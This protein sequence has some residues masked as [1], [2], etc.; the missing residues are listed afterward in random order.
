[1]DTDKLAKKLQNLSECIY[2]KGIDELSCSELH[3]VISHAVM[4]LISKRW[5]EC[6]QMREK[7]RCACYF[8]AEFLVGKMVFNNLM[9][10]NLTDEFEQALAKCGR[11]LSEVDN[12]GDMA[13]GNGGLGRLAACFLESAATMALPLD[14]Y[15]IKYKFGL[16]KQEIENG[17]QHEA[18]DDWTRSGDFFTVRRDE[19]SVSL[20]IAGKSVT[21]VPY[22]MPIIGFRSNYI[23]TLRL[24]Q[25]EPKQEFDFSEFNKQNYEKALSD[26]NAAENLSR[27]LYPNDSERRGKLL[28]LAQQYFFCAASVYDKMRSFKKEHGG[29]KEFEKYVTIQ[30]ND[31]HPVISI[32]EFIRLFQSEGFTFDEALRRAKAVFNYT[33]HTVMPE[34]LECWDLDLIDEIMPELV[35][36]ILLIDSAFKKEAALA[37]IGGKLEITDG[38]SVNMAYLAVYVSA[39]VNG[40]AKLHTGILKER[41]L[42]TWH[43]IYPEKFQNKTNGITPRRWLFLCNKGLSG[44]I[45]ELLGSEAWVAELELLNNLKKHAENSDVL[46]RFAEIKE[47]NK[48]A[49]SAYIEKYENVEIK[50]KMI[51]DIQIKRLHEYKRQLLNVMSII[52]IYYEIKNGEISD[53]YPTAFIFGAKAAPGYKRAKGIIKLINEV[54]RVIDEDKKVSPF[55]KVHFVHDYNVSYAERLVPAA[56]V[57]EQISTAGT[58][59]S[60]TGNMKFM[61]NGA[62][63]LGTYDGANI[64][65]IDEAGVQNN[66]IFGAKYEQLKKIE[67]SYDPMEIYKT[68]KK[69]RRALDFIISPLISDGGTG[70]FKELYDSL[71]T[72]ADWH[73]AD[74]YYLLYDFDSYLEAKLKINRD[75]RQRESFTKKCFLNTASSAAFSSDRA[76][77]EYA[78]DIWKIT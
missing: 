28:R 68:N 34:A 51:F 20:K 59:A 74:M 3:G 26:K 54:A 45:S 62:V 39:N 46:R 12:V 4:G 21:A 22:D 35:R 43:E 75:Y 9:E 2:C 17:F 53:F 44:L 37:G 58:E 38:K 63:T 61:L 13:L 57:S 67:N 72:G 47:Q 5:G 15:G 78:A 11:S 8:S 69:V 16:F 18:L 29:L 23:S 55:I 30:L 77:K 27:V 48:K 7:S 19:D 32:V 64:E 65:I 49:L 25:A 76:V 1:M 33:N 52:E 42:K 50:P 56:D 31:T 66:Y 70:I 60:G 40:V 36:I 6:R 10:L 14:G 73:R 41:V 71:L 24:W